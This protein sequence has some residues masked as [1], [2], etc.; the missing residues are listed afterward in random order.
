M[1]AHIREEVLRLFEAHR[2]APGTPYDESHFLDFLLSR[3]KSTR[4]VH[5]SFLGLR[6]YNAFINEVQLHF[7]ICLSL[8]DFEANYPLDK[9]VQRVAELQH[10]RRS[11]LAS[12]RS[13][14][15]HGFGWGTVVICNLLAVALV[16]GAARAS[17]TLTLVLVVALLLANAAVARFF[18]RWR[19][20]QTRLSRQLLAGAS[21]DA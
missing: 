4:A 12:F 21:D 9:F 7:S 2:S 13:Q 14:Q 6:R 3:P 10:S 11:S 18:L 16:A 17:D 19:S 8:R 15:R 5:N 1:S 20:Y